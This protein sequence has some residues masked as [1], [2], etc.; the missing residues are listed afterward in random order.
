[1]VIFNSELTE[2]IFFDLEFYVP[3]SEREKPGASLLANP[4][5]DDQF[6][7]GGVFTRYWP[8]KETKQD[9]QFQ[10]YWIWNQKTEKKVLRSIYEY[11][12]NSW[13]II[14]NKDPRQADL[15]LCGIGISRFDLPIL[16]IRSV[17]NRI[18]KS[19]N[20]FEVYFKTK[21]VDLSN[22]GISFFNREK[23]MYPKTVNQIFSRFGLDQEKVPSTHVWDKYDNEDYEWIEKR[24]ERE[25]RDCINLYQILCSKICPIKNKNLKKKKK[26]NG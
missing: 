15:I 14:K 3:S 9:L 11:F 6:L 20:I 25:V 16:Y 2:T 7:L 13:D 4:L 10:H 8:L 17:K 24:T 5:K 22:V 12:Q 18:D 26:R 21:P 19:E 23:V 1:M